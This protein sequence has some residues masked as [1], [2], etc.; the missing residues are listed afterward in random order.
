[1]IKS[2]AGEVLRCFRRAINRVANYISIGQLFIRSFSSITEN[3]ILVVSIDDFNHGRYGFQLINYFSKGGY[4]IIF[5]KSNGFLQNLFNYDRL[6]FQLPAV[7]LW[8]KGRKFKGKYIAWLNL[9]CNYLTTLPFSINKEIKID[10]N[11]FNAESDQLTSFKMPFYIHPVMNKYIAIKTNIKKQNSILFYGQ[12]DL[13]YDPK[14][15]K[16]YFNLISRK[17]VY[18]YIKDSDIPFI[19]PKSYEEFLENLNDRTL[20]NKLF[21]IDSNKVWIP[22][23]NWIDILRRFDF[24]I[25][26]PGVYMPLS[27]NVIEAIAVGTIP[28]IQY[29]S[30]FDPPLIDNKNC[31]AFNSLLHLKERIEEINNLKRDDIERIQKKVCLYFSQNINPVNVVYKWEQAKSNSINIFFNG[32]EYSLSMIKKNIY[33][34]VSIRI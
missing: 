14:W 10:L 20:R 1:M 2:K 30:Y 29:N 13:Y 18:D 34:G 32:E 27:H 5:F 19:A 9:N 21:F 4:Y 16:E 3:K 8:R 22:P 11:Y 31:F 7:S 26:T 12:S 25:A 6:I 28:I 24:F 15:I 17:E 33:K 23:D